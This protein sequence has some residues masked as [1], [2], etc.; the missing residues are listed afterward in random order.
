M[1]LQER[2]ICFEW[3]VK[4]LLHHKASFGV[5]EGFFTLL[6]QENIEIIEFLKNES[7]H[8]TPEDKF[9]HIDIKA[10]NDQG[11]TLLIV[12]E[13]MREIYY[14]ERILDGI[15]PALTKHLSQ[16]QT[17]HE[18]KK[19][20]FISILYF[21]LGRGNDYLYYGQNDFIG[22]HTG[23]SLEIAP[24]KRNAIVYKLPFTTSPEYFLIRL[25]EFHKVACTLL[26]EWIH[27]LKT[28]SI[29]PDTKTPG[30]EEAREKLKYYAMTPQERYAYDE[31]INAIMI[32]NDVLSTARLEG[33]IEAKQRKLEEG[34]LEEKRQVA[35]N[36]KKLGLSTDMIIHATN[37]S[38]EEIEKL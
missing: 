34:R 31:H 36:L 38:S 33:Q 9:Y 17:C 21:D 2:Y 27:Y 22:I 15:S 28:G 19:T 7:D 29:S 13:N 1:E 5:L 37:L 32:Q 10:K 8:L 14:F 24:H 18:I 12:I 20:Y 4:H 16:E 25:N 11:E 26:E 30:L 35:R 23:D 3:A 6:L